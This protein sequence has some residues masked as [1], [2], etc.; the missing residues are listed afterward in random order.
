MNSTPVSL[1]RLLLR[2]V[3]LGAFVLAAAAP[4]VR[5]QNSYASPTYF[6]TI[7]GSV[8][9][10]G[11]V[12][13]TGSAAR[14]N[15]P[16]GL[17]VGSSEVLY[18]AEY[19]NDA[20]RIVRPGGVVSTLLF[21][22]PSE[23]IPLG[24]GPASVAVGANGVVYAS[25]YR[26]DRIMAIPSPGVTTTFAGGGP[27]GLGPFDGV[28]TGAS[29]TQPYGLAIDS[30]GNLYVG[31]E[32]NHAIRKI[33]PTAAVTILAGPGPS[34][35]A[36]PGYVDGS[37]F[38]AR[39]RM[40]RGVA[41]DADFNVYVADWGNHAIRKITPAGVV[42]TLAGLGG[43]PGSN[44][45][46]GT[47]ARFRNPISVAVDAARNVYV[48]DFGNHLV[49][50]ITPAGVVTTLAGSA[51]VT[52]SADGLGAAARFNSPG[53]IA[54]DAAGNLFVTDYSN[55]TIRTSVTPPAFAQPLAS[56]VVPT[57]SSV[58]FVAT[59]P[60]SN[61]YA[62]T[63]FQWR[64][65]GVP[66]AGATSATLTLVNVQN[67][68]AGAYSV[69][70]TNVAGSATSNAAQLGLNLAPA[71]TTQPAS[72]VVPLGTTAAFTVTTTSAT[73]V[74]YQWQKDG[75]PIDGAT[76]TALVIP[77]VQT[78]NLG[79][80][81]VVATNAAGSTTS[82]VAALSPLQPPV[83]STQPLGQSVDPGATVTLS[84]AVTGTSPTT[85][86][87][88]KDGVALPGAT[89]PTLVLSNVQ[90]ATLG[91]YSVVASN[92][93]G[94]TT[95]NGATLAF[96]LSTA[97]RL[98]NLSIRSTA[99]T[100]AQTLIVGLVIGG[101]STTGPKPLLIR[102]VGPALGGFG[103]PGALSDPVLNV[104]AGATG[105][106]ANDNWGGDTQVSAVG[107]QFGAF[108]LGAAT[109]RD[110]ALYAPAFG[111]GAYTVQVSGVGGTTGVALAEIYDATAT[112]L[113][114]PSTPR[115][116]N[117]S[118]RTQVGTGADILITGFSI[119]GTTPVRLLI[120]AVGPALTAFGVTGV[121]TDPKL[122]LY[123]GST[124]LQSNDNWGGGALIA[125]A[126]SSVGAFALDPASRDAVLLVTLPPGAYTAQVSGVNNA[127]GVAL[128]EAYEIP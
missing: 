110:A 30:A 62:P 78:A 38:S 26:R 41:V 58:T 49:R 36:S 94:G 27:T 91:T 82:A 61:P 119:S 63:T 104:F 42:S 90:A 87:W 77:T 116:I 60:A 125:N 50:R 92:L 101:A 68:N 56:Q 75:V 59:V 35:L 22:P 43:A 88:R 1:H 46:T 118:A 21:R 8:G 23:L 67:V 47:A 57:G 52:G 66:L 17:A 86:Q 45:G 126:A 69:V 2:C 81:T 122:D 127:T 53:G 51:G 108:A 105:V 128:V 96:I 28:G 19:D 25:S 4:P 29:F 16:Q 14:F 12:D 44:D 106:A 73:P 5:A 48:A 123:E 64:K 3:P 10:S 18:V 80:Y 32:G 65:D 83:F 13:G 15:G 98:S 107:A 39:F 70:V 102:G 54:I 115:L 55:R 74:T 33:S 72:Q 117:V 113:F 40:P 37:G 85:Y 93:A 95:S 79:N 109:S 31:D 103:V 124:L 71:F 114:M 112:D 34:L 84:A 89:S 20:V 6:T 99:G 100:G 120:R 11:F 9:Q 111:A 7:A 97:G 121:L 76:T 24:L